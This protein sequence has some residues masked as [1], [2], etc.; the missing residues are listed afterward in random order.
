MNELWDWLVQ[1]NRVIPAMRSPGVAYSSKY[2]REP[3]T[4]AVKFGHDS[5]LR[6][7]KRA[8]R[9]GMVPAER[10]QVID[11]AERSA[12]RR[13]YRYMHAVAARQQYAPG[14]I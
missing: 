4:G 10:M 5:G 11:T 2:R 12:A 14:S 9:R 3:G 6:K 8:M 1:L 13:H 7:L